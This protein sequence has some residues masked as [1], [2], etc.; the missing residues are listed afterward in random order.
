MNHKDETIIELNRTKLL[1]LV[2]GSCAFVL[3]G[4]WLLT[5]DAGEIRAGRSFRLFFNNPLVVYG[6]GLATIV[7]FAFTGQYAL[8]KMFDKR[9]GLVLN[10]EGIIDNASASAAGFIPWSEVAGSGIYEIQKT[11]MLVIGLRDPQK[12]LGRGNAL[13][14]TLN[15]ANSNMVGS[16]VSISS[17]ALKIEFA[18]LVSLFER[19]YQKYG[20]VSAKREG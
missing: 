10:S 7:S 5:F 12:Y 11:R 3:V 8:R 14:R 6:A 19:Y 17:T 9:P 16:P 18:E 2:L 1:L 15:K 20:G 4:V 13:K